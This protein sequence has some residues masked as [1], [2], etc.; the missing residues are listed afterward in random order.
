MSETIRQTPN[1]NEMEGHREKMYQEI[2]YVTVSVNGFMR[3]HKTLEFEKQ[4]RKADGRRRR[5]EAAQ[6]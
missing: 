2:K 6:L 5:A 4:K 3:E 1:D